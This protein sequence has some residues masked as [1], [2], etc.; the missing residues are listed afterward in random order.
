MGLELPVHNEEIGVFRTTEAAGLNV[1]NDRYS[2]PAPGRLTNPMAA[3]LLRAMT[4]PQLS[5]PQQRR[6]TFA[7]VS[8]EAHVEEPAQ[9]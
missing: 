1:D 5:L 3:G 9:A 4:L 7:T 8:G 6:W 2:L